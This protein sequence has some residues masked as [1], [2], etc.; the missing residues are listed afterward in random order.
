MRLRGLR[1]HWNEYGKSDPFWAILTAPDKKG[2]RWSIDEFLQTGRDEIAGVIAYL[3]EHH[4]N[5][6]RRH[7]LDFGCGAGRLTHALAGYFDH[8][9]GVDIAPSMIDVARRLHASVPGVEFRVNASDKLE[10]VE[11]ESIDF[12]YTRLVL[13]HMPP[14]YVRA[15]LAEFVRVLCPGGV[16]VFQLPAE[17]AVPVSVSGRG[18]KRL[19]PL[20]LVSVIR[21]VRALRQFPRM[22]IHGLPRPEVERLL[23]QLGAP[24]V[25][26][27]DD[28]AHGADTPGYRYCAVKG[29]PRAEPAAG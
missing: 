20:P 19:L 9:T 3:D 7:A 23:A 2:N 17:N 27:V 14:R 18:V 26:V 8:V 12:V 1:R 29:A 11:S 15:Y 25:D 28:R 13:Q 24:V 4:L 10:S 16:L 22:E 6:G 5:G 21:A